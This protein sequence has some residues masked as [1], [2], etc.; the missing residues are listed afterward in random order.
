MKLSILKDDAL[1]SLQSVQYSVSSRSVMPILSGVRVEA[2][3]GSLNLSTTDL[4]TSTRTSCPASVD[5]EGKCV[6]N[7]KILTEIIRDMSDEKVTIYLSGSELAVEGTKSR[8]KLYTMPIEDFPSMP[9]INVTVVEEMDAKAFSNA[10]QIV[11][12]AASRDE[13]RPTLMGVLVELG[14]REIRLVSTDSY[15]LAVYRMGDDLNIKEEGSF[16]IPAAAL[17]NLARI[18]GPGEK[19]YMRK[20][21]SGGQV[22][23]GSEGFSYSIRLI[24]GKF[25]RYEQFIPESLDNTVEM[26]KEEMIKAIKRASIV[27]PTLKLEIK[28]GA[29]T[30]VSESKEVGEGREEMEV[31]YGGPNLTI[32]F[33]SKFLEDGIMSVAEERVLL[34]VTEPLKPGLIRGKESEDFQYVIMPIRI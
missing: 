15:R 23:F 8:F 14:E 18:T 1:R 33:N 2:K 26:N 31:V 32:A 25:P 22:E 11:S 34:N 4:E 12:K 20:D 5:D 30:V 16:I 27:S 28:E 17:A 24:E 19:I 13:K 7:H 6:V 10:V 9:D 29:L 21:E 3:E